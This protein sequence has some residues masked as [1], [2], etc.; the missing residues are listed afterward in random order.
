VDTREVTEKLTKV[1]MFSECTKRELQAIV[2]AAKEVSHREGH[3]IAQEGD[4]GVGFFL[5]IDGAAK[6]SIG[7]KTRAKL[8]AGDFFG[9][10][11]L[12]DRGPRTATVT[13]TTPIKLIGL[14]G[15]VFRGLLEEHPAIA[16]KMLEVVAR[17]LRE[18]G[19]PPTS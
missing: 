10:V 17:R 11:A 15:W 9:E 18:A 6:V 4:R 13:S 2:R 7:G 1:P 12:L 16:L 8:G 5:I 3:V 14:T 19:P